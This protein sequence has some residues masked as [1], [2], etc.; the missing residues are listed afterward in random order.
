MG[1]CSTV[2]GSPQCWARTCHRRDL[3]PHR[4]YG[5]PRRRLHPRG[6]TTRSAS[7]GSGCASC[8]PA[9][10]CDAAHLPAAQP[11][12]RVPRFCPTAAE[13]LYDRAMERRWTLAGAAWAVGFVLVAAQVPPLLMEHS[14]DWPSAVAGAALLA[15]G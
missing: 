12:A 2:L 15:L 6:W 8:S 10:A 11:S 9:R 14:A 3:A 1:E 7:T 4:S 5:R 13:A